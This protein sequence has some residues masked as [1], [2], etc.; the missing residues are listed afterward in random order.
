MHGPSTRRGAQK[1]TFTPRLEALEDRALPTVSAPI[2]LS[3]G[4][5]EFN[6]T[7]TGNNTLIITDDG[8]GDVSF[9]TSS[10]AKPTAIKGGPVNEIIFNAGPGS[11][12]FTY[13]MT[14]NAPLT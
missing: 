10:T 8:M 11:Y 4:V 6:T 3:P 7:G 14:N 5:V 9:A 1:R 13:T 12:T 2:V